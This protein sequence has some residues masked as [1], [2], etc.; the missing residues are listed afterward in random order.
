VIPEVLAI[1]LA[2]AIGVAL[3]LLL[4]HEGR[5]AIIVGEGML[6][7]I[8]SCAAIL[9]VSAI[10]TIAWSRSLLLVMAVLVGAIAWWFARHRVGQLR[11]TVHY[12]PASAI[13]DGITA[14][15][16]LGYSLFSTMAPLWEFDY[17]CNWGL[18]GK[19][20]WE[21]HGIDWS[22]LQNAFHRAIHP[23]YPPLL[24]LSFDVLA[25]VRGDWNDRALGLLNVVFA[26]ALLLVVRRL[27]AEETGS[28]LAGAFAAAAMLAFAASPWIGLAESPLVAYGTMAILLLRIDDSRVNVAAVLLGLA[29]SAK[30]EGLTLIVA[31]AVALVIAGR[32]R[33]VPRLWPAIAIPLPWLVARLM[34]DIPT[35]LATG[36]VFSRVL[37]HV[38]N[39]AP[40]LEA[41]AH[42]PVGKPLY[43]L[44]IIAAFAILRSRLVSRERFALSAIVVQFAFYIGAY[45]SSP[46][47]VDWHLHWSWERVVSHLTPTLTYVVIVQLTLEAARRAAEPQPAR[48]RPSPLTEGPLLLT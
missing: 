39:P 20:F 22:F 47:D 40:L 28:D 5:G 26:L 7:G 36:N 16:L 33:L 48:Q 34:R 13:F 45:L 37:T 23:D 41:L 9:F 30:N 19:L 6:L 1:V 15:G 18:K 43:W 24:P 12:S 8:A 44:G 3:A 38:E 32:A 21:A 46:H 14:L 17:I 25:V 10:A 31:V 11:S 35:D 27:A 2:T 4:D 42:Y 29:A